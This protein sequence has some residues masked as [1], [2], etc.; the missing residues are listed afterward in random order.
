[1]IRYALLGLDLRWVGNDCC[2][3]SDINEAR[4]YE[5]IEELSEDLKIFDEPLAYIIV[6][7]NITEKRVIRRSYEYKILRKNKGENKE[8]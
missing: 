4:F 5:T 1:M 3:T 2:P 8:V 7:V 6:E